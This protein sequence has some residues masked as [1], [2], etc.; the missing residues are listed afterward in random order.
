MERGRSQR[1]NPTDRTN[2]TEIGNI[3]A[4]KRNALGREMHE[5]FKE[6]K[7]ERGRSREY[8]DAWEIE[9]ARKKAS[10]VRLSPSFV[11]PSRSPPSLSR[12]RQSFS[13]SAR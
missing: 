3:R 1:T 9:I 4:G 6:N 7:M 13:V 10:F 5:L 2:P 8:K 11:S 12:V